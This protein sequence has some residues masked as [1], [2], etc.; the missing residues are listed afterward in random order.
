MVSNGAQ[1]LKW[2]SLELV[3]PINQ[4]LTAGMDVRVTLLAVQPCE[5]TEQSTRR[6]PIAL[7]TLLLLLL[8]LPLLLLPPCTAACVA[9]AAHTTAFLQATNAW[10]CLS[11]TAHART[12]DVHQVQ[13]ANKQR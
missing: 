3:N 1:Q 10:Y 4:K 11:E 9:L 6:L 5:I 12:A 8:L 2:R 7:A 13:H